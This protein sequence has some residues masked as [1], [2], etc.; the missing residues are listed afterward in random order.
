MAG[1]G[2][3][4]SCQSHSEGSLETYE[5]VRCTDMTQTQTLIFRVQALRQIQ[6]E[7]EI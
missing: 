4:R 5:V 3:S 1:V 6:M 7:I 2:G